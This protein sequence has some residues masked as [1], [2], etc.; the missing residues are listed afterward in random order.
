MTLNIL[1][2]RKLLETPKDSK[3]NSTE[4]EE[5]EKMKQRQRH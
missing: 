5:N 3:E 1:L 2:K 4:F